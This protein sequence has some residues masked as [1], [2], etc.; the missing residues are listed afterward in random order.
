M[1][2]TRRERDMW[3]LD[4]GVAMTESDAKGFDAP[5][6]YAARVVQPFRAT[7]N[8]EAYRKFW[9]RHGEARPGL[10]GLLAPLPRYIVTPEVAKHRLFVWAP[11]CVLPDKNLQVV[12]RA[13]DTTLGLLHSR[14]H[15]GWSLRLGTSLE[16]R[17]RYTPTST[18]E[19]F[20]FPAGLTPADT[21]HQ[22]T[23]TLPDGAV[24][25]ADLDPDVRP[26]AEAIAR[27]ARAWWRCATAGSTR[28]N[29]PSGCPKSCRWA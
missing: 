16:D 6:E 5:Y 21:A 15:E 19:T 14:L 12:P 13:D 3:I 4:F 1:D 7:N 17:P 8:R 2:V 22:R 10:R 18:F 29:G 25:P 11:T 24:I 27:A 9:W 20:P 23:E 28:R 26:Q